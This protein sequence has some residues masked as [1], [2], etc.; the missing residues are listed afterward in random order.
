MNKTYLIG[1]ITF[2]VLFIFFVC[3]I[4]LSVETPSELAS[5]SIYL[6]LLIV[7]FLG[8]KHRQMT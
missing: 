4:F 2:I 1:S 3:Y 6:I 7:A 5:K 8:F